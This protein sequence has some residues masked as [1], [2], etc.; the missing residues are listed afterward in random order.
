M[1]DIQEQISCFLCLKGTDSDQTGIHNFEGMY[2]GSL[3]GIQF[4]FG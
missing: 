4:R 1:M 2:K 3:D